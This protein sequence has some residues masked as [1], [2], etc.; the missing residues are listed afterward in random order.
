MRGPAGSSK[1][2]ADRVFA[3][4]DEEAGRCLDKDQSRSLSESARNTCSLRGQVGSWGWG[5]ARG[6]EFNPQIHRIKATGNLQFGEK[7]RME[8]GPALTTPEGLGSFRAGSPAVLLKRLGKEA[9][10]WSGVGGSSG[11]RV[12]IV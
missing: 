10:E 1:G 8:L 2:G 5:V 9:A 4:L 7:V 6:P 11:G 12:S 3:E